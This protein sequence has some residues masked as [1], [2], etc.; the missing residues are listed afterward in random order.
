[1]YLVARVGFVQVFRV[2]GLPVLGVLAFH[3]LYDVNRTIF[4]GWKILV[5][6][7]RRLQHEYPRHG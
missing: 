7:I 2:E 6:A 5:Q 3:V 4:W 1:M